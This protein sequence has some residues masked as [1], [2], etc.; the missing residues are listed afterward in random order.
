L[1]ECAS[2]IL[3]SDVPKERADI[4]KLVGSAAGK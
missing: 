2:E 1:Q 3:S 4:E